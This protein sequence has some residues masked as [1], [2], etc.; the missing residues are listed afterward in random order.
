V[1]TVMIPPAPW[2]GWRPH[3]TATWMAQRRL[4]QLPR[5][6]HAA[7]W[8]PTC[9]GWGLVYD[10]GFVETTTGEYIWRCEPDACPSCNGSGSV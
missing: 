8:C 10:V 7:T 3:H 4:P 2:R 6:E 9:Q 5:E 1:T